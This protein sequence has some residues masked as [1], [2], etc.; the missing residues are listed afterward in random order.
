M[1]TNNN[2]DN[3]FWSDNVKK[4]SPYV[5]GEQPKINNLVKLN[6]NENPFAPSP[7]VLQTI[8]DY[9][10]QNNENTNAEFLRLYPNPDSSELVETLANYHNVENSQI[11]VG[12]GSD[13]VLAFAFYA[14]LNHNNKK[15]LFPDISYSFYPVYCQ[16]FNI[17]FQQIP[18][19]TNFEIDVANDYLNY[20]NK[21][22]VGGIIFPNP[23]APTGL[24]VNINLIEKLCTTYAN[25]PII[26][27]E[28]YIDFAEDN[29]SNSAL[30]LLKLKQYKNLLII[31][32]FSK[33]RA[34]AGMRIGYAIGDSNLITALNYAKNSFNSYPLDRISQIAAIASVNDEN[35]FQ[36]KRNEVINI[37]KNLVLN[38]QKLNFTIIPS[39]ANFIFAKHNNDN[40]FS[41][42]F[43]Q[44]E[45]RKYNIIVRRFNS[46]ERIKNYLR[47]TIGDSQ[48]CD[49]LIEK[50]AE[51]V[52]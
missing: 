34:L 6:T 29:I 12:N 32:T 47:I 33:S 35:Y 15:V 3:K 25:I 13:E 43:L 37:R 2:S 44:N 19:T 8:K 5:P 7:K 10:L 46:P 45:L 42:E 21:D 48:Q 49:L 23:N 20:K 40:K 31:R 26:I 14:L 24:L 39:A 16:F 22:E 28:A 52:G 11:F 36:N 51:I 1:N 27:D 38:L 18:L 4:L 41:G 17:N 9:F 30:S 50:L